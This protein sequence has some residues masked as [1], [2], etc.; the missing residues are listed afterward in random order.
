MTLHLVRHGLAAAGLD[1][2]DPGLAPLGREQAQAAANA[3]AHLR[4]ARFAVSPLRRTRETADPFARAFGMEPEVRVEVAE[5]FD[6][7]LPPAERKA[8]IGPFM[9]GRWSEQSEKLL[10]W[11]ERA[12]AALRELGGG[13]DAVVVS[14]YIAICAAIG[15]ATDDDRVVPVK[16]ANA[17]ITTLEARADGLSLTAA[18]AIDHLAPEQVTGLATALPGGP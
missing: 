16:L 8:I 10:A 15:A 12:L 7:D 4:P 17:S 14:H 5:V 13:G 6:P 11:R 1:D 18:G 3:L 2:L 9:E